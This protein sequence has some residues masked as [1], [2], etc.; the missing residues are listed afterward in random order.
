VLRGGSWINNGRNARSAY[1]NH[2]EPGNRNANIGFRLARAQDIAGWH[3][4]T[5][6]PSCPRFWGKKQAA[7]GM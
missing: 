6:L 4:L 2:D 7:R 5:R 3:C 1:R